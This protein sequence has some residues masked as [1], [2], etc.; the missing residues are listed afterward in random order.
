MLSLPPAFVLSQDQTLKLRIQ[1][2]AL[3]TFLTRTHTSISKSA[4]T[5]QDQ[6]CNFLKNVTAKV[7]FKEPV[8]LPIPQTSPPT[9]LFLLF[10]QLSNNRRHQASIPSKPKPTFQSA[11]QNQTLKS[12]FR[13]QSQ[14][15]V[16][17][18][19]AAPPPSFSDTAYR[20]TFPK[21]SILNRHLN[22]TF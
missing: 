2:L 3:L 16:K 13:R 11:Q 15:R 10:I 14:E 21:P 19:P 20:T 22:V 5:N 1:S 12:K 18:S 17:R 4:E 9:F 7:S 6:E 8:S